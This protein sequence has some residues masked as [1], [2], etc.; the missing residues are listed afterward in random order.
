MHTPFF[1]PQKRAVS[2]CCPPTTTPAPL[3]QSAILT[4]EAGT[5]FPATTTTSIRARGYAWSGG[6]QPIA[7]V[8]VSADDGASWTVARL[9]QQESR[10]RWLGG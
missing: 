3:E 8:D 6:G 9:V 5:V 2:C 10:V 1:M 7:R 4:P